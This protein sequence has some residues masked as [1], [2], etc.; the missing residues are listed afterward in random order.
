MQYRSFFGLALFSVILICSYIPAFAQKVDEITVAYFLEWPTPNQFAQANKIYEKELGVKINWVSFDGGTAMSAAMAS[1][2]VQISFSQ[3]LTS[4]LLAVAAGQD[5]QAVGV[6]VSYSDNDNCVVR[7]ELKIRKGNVSELKGKKVAVPLGTAAHSGFL[8][9]MKYFGIAESDLTIVDMAP[10]DAAAVFSQ[11]DTDIAMACGW[12]GS[13]RKMK[14][15]GNPIIE[16]AEK[17]AV[18]GKAFDLITAPRAFI[19]EHPELIQKFLKVTD[20]MNKKFA[21][22]P[23][24]M[25]PWISKAAGMDTEEAANVIS[26]FRFPNATD[27]ASKN[28]LGKEVENEIKRTARNLESKGIIKAVKPNY[29]DLIEPSFIQRLS[30]VRV[31][32]ILFGTNRKPKIEQGVVTF[33]A[34]RDK[35]LHRGLLKISIPEH[36]LHDRGEIERPWDFKIPFTDIVIFSQTENPLEHFTTLEIRL[37]DE[38][39]FISKATERVRKSS[40]FEDQALIYVHGYNVPF[41]EAG[42]R[43]AQMVY[44]MGFDGVPLLYSWPSTGEPDGYLADL[45]SSEHSAE[46]LVEFIEGILKSMDLKKVHVIAHSMGA[47]ALVRA[48]DRMSTSREDHKSQ[49][50]EIVL[51]APDIDRSIFEQIYANIVGKVGGLTLYAS[52]KDKAMIASRLFRKNHP[53]VGDVPTGKGPLV[54]EEMHTIDVSKLGSSMFG[55][56]HSDYAEEPV[57]LKDIGLLFS[58]W[59][60]MRSPKKRVGGLIKSK[61]STGKIFW[62]Y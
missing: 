47:N 54:F 39:F 4:F 52:S 25:M 13:L 3:G 18:V 2:D 45:D 36:R 58:Q 5:L 29:D 17:E 49:I 27:Q 51:A 43:L 30:D 42:Y 28:W 23:A 22:E 48:V 21:S 55:T 56:E 31:M 62:K 34:K 57:L 40:T 61:N 1:G 15:H 59:D 6:A 60:T 50:N 26:T 19:S 38:K 11:P 24:Q 33:S 53:R 46:F 44:D 7:S 20:D 9:Q 35:K 10:S 41:K 16:G 32:E 14:Q 37:T 12:G 8:A